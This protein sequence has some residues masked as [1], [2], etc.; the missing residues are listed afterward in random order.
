MIS[1]RQ[2]FLVLYLL[3][4]IWTNPILYFAN[5]GVSMFKNPLLSYFE[6]LKFP[7]WDTFIGDNTGSYYLNGNDIYI[8]TYYL[9]APVY[10]HDMP[11]SFNYGGMGAWAGYYMVYALEDD[12]KFMTWIYRSFETFCYK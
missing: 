6:Q 3:L 2:K 11:D 1:T 5:Q 8:P 9:F 4:T 10:S 12:C 7:S